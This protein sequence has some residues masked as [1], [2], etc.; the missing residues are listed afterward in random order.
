MLWLFERNWVKMPPNAPAYVQ[1][2]EATASFILVDTFSSCEDLG[3]MQRVNGAF[4]LSK[5]GCSFLQLP[6]DYHPEKVKSFVD[7]LGG[8]KPA[9]F[10]SQ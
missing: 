4:F 8:W 1:S 10:L 5:I 3:K 9:F 6:S 7:T 2:V